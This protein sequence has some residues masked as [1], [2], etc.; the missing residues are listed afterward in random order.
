MVPAIQVR[1]VPEPIYRLLADLAEKEHRSLAQ[2]TLAVLARG[3]GVGSGPKARR[4]N[5]LAEIAG[6]SSGAGNPHRARALSDPVRIIRED[7][8]R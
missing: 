5:L 2:Q 7:R 6:S 4:K 1:D 8:K 3:L